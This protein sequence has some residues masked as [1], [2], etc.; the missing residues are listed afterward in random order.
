MMKKTTNYD[1]AIFSQRYKNSVYEEVIKAVEKAAEECG[2]TRSGIAGTLGYSKAHISR[3]LSGPSN[4][5][6]DTISNLLYA[7]DA[8]MVSKVRFFADCPKE[9][10]YHEMGEPVIEAKKPSKIMYYTPVTK[11]KAS[12]LVMSKKRHVE[13]VSQ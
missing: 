13:M 8:E 3:L 1:A 12:G 11:H 2:T 10:H 9:N 5:T 7:V 4:W 6:L